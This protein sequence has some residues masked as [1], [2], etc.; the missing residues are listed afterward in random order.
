MA[1]VSPDTAT[2]VALKN[3]VGFAMSPEQKGA[4]NA[5]AII[6]LGIPAADTAAKFAALLRDNVARLP[7]G[8]RDPVLIELGFHILK[9]PQDEQAGAVQAY[10]AA[11]NAYSGESG[12]VASLFEEARNHG[13]DGLAHLVIDNLGKDAIRNGESAASIAGRLGVTSHEWLLVEL[14]AQHAAGAMD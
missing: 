5:Q 7:Q 11:G 2:K 12:L 4:I 1:K 3:A 8:N 10:V 14:V 9:M 6:D 13:T